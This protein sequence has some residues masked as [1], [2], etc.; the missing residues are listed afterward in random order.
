LQAWLSKADWEQIHPEM[1]QES[2]AKRLRQAAGAICPP[3]AEP[4]H[5]ARLLGGASQP[6]EV[7]IRRCLRQ[8]SRSLIKQ[9]GWLLSWST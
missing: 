2:T 5:A 7:E 4:T 6:D 1:I 8:S 3:L 9:A